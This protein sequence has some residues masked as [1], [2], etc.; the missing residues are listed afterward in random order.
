MIEYLAKKNYKRLASLIHKSPKGIS[1]PPQP[2]QWYLEQ[3]QSIENVRFCNYAHYEYLKGNKYRFQ[4]KSEDLL[5]FRNV[6]IRHD[7]DH[8]PKSALKMAKIEAE[9][10]ITA[11]Y[12][13]LTTDSVYATRYW[14]SKRD[15][16]LKQMLEIQ[17]MGHEVGLHYDFMGD[18]FSKGIPPYENVKHLVH[19]FR[20]AGIK[21]SGCVSHGSS[22]TRWLLKGKQKANFPKEFINYN[23]WNETSK[24]AS[25]LKLN[26]KTL[27]TPVFSLES[28]GLKY[29]AYHVSRD[30]YS[31]DTG[32]VFWR[33]ADP[34]DQAKALKDGQI[35]TILTHPAWWKGHLKG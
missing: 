23:I 34:I 32:G 18:Y 19:E 30:L 16:F 22:A 3:L 17:E 1:I 2:Y 29:E 21:L 35:L 9:M 5:G 12:Y 7:V 24:F 20:E 10:D 25:K 6:F 4:I 15:S 31:S 14:K 33:I 8:G 13:F 27:N 26:K 28:F 11:N